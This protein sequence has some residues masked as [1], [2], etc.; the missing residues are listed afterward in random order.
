MELNISTMTAIDASEAVRTSDSIT[1]LRKVAKDLEIPHSGNTGLDTLREKIMKVLE[2]RIVSNPNSR[3]EFSSS[4]G[5]LDDM[6]GEDGLD[7]IEVAKP[8]PKKKGPSVSQMLKMDPSEIEDVALRRNVI[9]AQALRMVRVR[10]QNVDPADSVLDGGIITILNKYT[11]KVSKY[12][13][14][15]EESEGGYH[16]PWMLYEHL[17]DWKFPL[18]K[19]V[20]GGQFGVKTYKTTMVNKFKI[21]ILPMLTMDELKELANHQRAAQSIDKVG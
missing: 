9:R 5:G 14:Y 20:K 12:V 11:S 10:I 4:F 13:P 15:G 21:D 3:D 17:R 2:D 18:R 6:F 1:D 19:E 7:E 8:I 16:I